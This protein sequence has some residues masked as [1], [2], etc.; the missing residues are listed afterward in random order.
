MFVKLS[1]DR[2]VLMSY[3]EAMNEKLLIILKRKKITQ[4]ELSKRT[5]LNETLL[6]RIITGRMRPTV[7]ERRIISKVLRTPQYKLFEGGGGIADA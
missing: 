4:R 3:V 2:L 6:S 7:L 1:L 5:G